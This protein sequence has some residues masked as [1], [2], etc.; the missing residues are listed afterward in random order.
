MFKITIDLAG[1]YVNQGKIKFG[2]QGGSPF[3]FDLLSQKRYIQ[4][5]SYR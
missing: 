1:K 5:I 2:N 4:S 3:L